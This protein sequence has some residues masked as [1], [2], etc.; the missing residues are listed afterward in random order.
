MKQCTYNVEQFRLV[1]F[2][3]HGNHFAIQ[4]G[5]GVVRGDQILDLLEPVLGIE[6]LATVGNVGS[7]VQVHQ[8]QFLKQDAGLVCSEAAT[9]EPNIEQ[10]VIF[11]VRF[12]GRCIEQE[13]AFG[14]FPLDTDFGFE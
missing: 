13:L 10:P 11:V 7:Q 4:V 2:G 9:V 5:G 12:L 3:D 14:V 1:G 6:E 8:P